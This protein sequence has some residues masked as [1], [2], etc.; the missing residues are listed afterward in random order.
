ME[1]INT[2]S[3]VNN[4]EKRKTGGKKS[5]EPKEKTHTTNIRN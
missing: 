3:K 1:I 5:N 4:I 2:L